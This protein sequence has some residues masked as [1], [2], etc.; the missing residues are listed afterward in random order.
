MIDTW[1][2]RD[3][4]DQVPIKVFREYDGVFSDGARLQVRAQDYARAMKMLAILGCGAAIVSCT[5]VG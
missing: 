4:L 3:P 1:P 2:L 5:R